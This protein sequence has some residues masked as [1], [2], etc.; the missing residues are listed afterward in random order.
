MDSVDGLGAEQAGV[1][2]AVGKG[3]GAKRLMSMSLAHDSPID[4]GISIILAMLQRGQSAEV[5]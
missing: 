1:G 2:S 3:E 4:N 5:S